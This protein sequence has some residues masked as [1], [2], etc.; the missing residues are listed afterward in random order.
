MNIDLATEKNINDLKVYISYQNRYKYFF[1]KY[2]YDKLSLKEYD[3]KIKE[4]N[5]DFGIS[6]PTM[7]QKYT[8]TEEFFDFDY[9][10]LINRF[11][12]EKL[13]IEELSILKSNDEDII[14]N[15]IEN[16]YKEIIKDNFR[17]N[18]Y[19]NEVYRVR[20][21]NSSKETNFIPN[22]NIVFKILYSK[23]NK[24]YSNEEYIKNMKDKREF[25]NN[26]IEEIS[27]EIKNIL[28]IDCSIIVEKLPN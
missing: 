1:E 13:S 12:V 24:K 15:L 28:D 22:N 18:E 23:N 19:T 3:K 25:L 27:E 20:Y 2:L 21:G 16:T 5:L 8:I 9:I 7:K 14:M 6:T 10:Y 26:I 11:Y 4:S 17:N